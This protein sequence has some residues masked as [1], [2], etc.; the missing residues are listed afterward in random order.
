MKI[1][2]LILMKG[3]QLEENTSGSKTVYIEGLTKRIKMTREYKK[4]M[5][6][7][8]GELGKRLKLKEV[9]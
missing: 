4:M 8:M 6:K 5:M 7:I 3:I 9:I 1:T 2:K